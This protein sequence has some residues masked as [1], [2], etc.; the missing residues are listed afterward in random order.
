[1]EFSL[2]ARKISNCIP[3]LR[4][5][6]LRVFLPNFGTLRS[7]NGMKTVENSRIGFFLWL[8]V[9]VKIVVSLG[10]LLFFFSGLFPLLSYPTTRTTAL[11][12]K[13]LSEAG[14]II[15][16]FLQ[17]DSIFFMKKVLSVLFLSL[18]AI[19]VLTVTPAAANNGDED[20]KGR[21][22]DHWMKW[23]Q[24]LKF[25]ERD[26]DYKGYWGQGHRL[27]GS[28]SGAP[29]SGSPSTP[30]GSGQSA[31]LDGGLSLLLAAGIGLGA[32][33]AH[34]MRMASRQ[35]SGAIPE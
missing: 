12:P 28:G 27:D 32:K 1:M 3:L 25:G 33:R 10:S 22:E 23:N 34:Q 21:K 31:P 17:T 7:Q 30:G 16:A 6:I 26:R 19:P 15:T 18:V 11:A 4:K 20:G 24:H 14:S 2:N 13:R 29:L 35:K 9:C 5:L 8:D